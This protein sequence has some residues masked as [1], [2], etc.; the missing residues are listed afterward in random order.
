MNEDRRKISRGS[1]SYRISTTG[2][3]IYYKGNIVGIV[4]GYQ[5]LGDEP[6]AEAQLLANNVLIAENEILNVLRR[7]N[8]SMRSMVDSIEK[9]LQQQDHE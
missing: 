4:P 9:S 3:I 2:A 8:K 1:F 6:I 5:P 7:K